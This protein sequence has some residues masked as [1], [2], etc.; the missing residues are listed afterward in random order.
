MSASGPP[1]TQ[2]YLPTQQPA[3]QTQP[4]VPSLPAISSKVTIPATNQLS[5]QAQQ[6]EAASPHSSPLTN[7]PM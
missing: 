2:C 4:M 1:R 3:A 6:H 5:Q 7:S